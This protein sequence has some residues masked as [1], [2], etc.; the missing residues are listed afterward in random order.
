MYFFVACPI[1]P[2]FHFCNF[3]TPTSLVVTLNSTYKL[4]YTVYLAILFV[5]RQFHPLYPFI[6]TCTQPRHLK[7]RMSQNLK[8]GEEISVEWNW[9]RK[10]R[11]I[12]RWTSSTIPKSKPGGIFGSMLYWIHLF[13]RHSMA[14]YIEEEENRNQHMDSRRLSG[15]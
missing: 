1:V 6:M 14:S 4:I 7:I 15:Q 3:S 8:F 11:N 2:L 5:L 13:S 12:L 9:P 10:T